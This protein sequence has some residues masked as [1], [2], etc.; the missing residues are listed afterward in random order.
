MESF[1]PDMNVEQA[2]RLLRRIETAPVAEPTPVDMG[3]I[4][5]VFRYKAGAEER[6]IH[7]KYNEDSV[8]KTKFMSDRFG[9][10]LGLPRVLKTG[11]FEGVNYTVSELVPGKPM[12]A[13]S[14][15]QVQ[16]VVPDLIR[17]FRAINRIRGRDSDGYGWIAA[18][19]TAAAAS[20]SGTCCPTARRSPASSIG[21]WRCS[22]TSCW[23]SP[24][25]TCG[26]L[27]SDS[28]N[29]SARRGRP[30]ENR[31]LDSTNAYYATGCLRDSTVYGF[32]PSRRINRHT[33]L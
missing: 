27:G 3:E 29:G 12:S 33:T 24:S 7:F 13:L 16:R 8:A 32:T 6:V 11:V 25:W 10:E 26:T 20:T 2:A 31:F 30:K 4:S 23:T 22:E 18:D 21:R 28:R 9:N 19:G 17:R 1:K 5:R 15:D 14:G